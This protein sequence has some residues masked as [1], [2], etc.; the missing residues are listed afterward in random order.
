MKRTHHLLLLLVFLSTWG[1]L[2][3][4]VGR[5]V[6]VVTDEVG[7]LEGVTVQYRGYNRGAVTDS[8]G[9]YSLP[10]SQTGKFDLEF[11]FLGYRAQ[12]IPLEIE[13][14][15]LTYTVDVVLQE[16]TRLL[17]TVEVEGAQEN[18]R[19]QV[20]LYRLDPATAQALPTP[21]QEFTRILATLPG[22]SATN[23][24]SSAYSVRGGNF[25]EN[26]VYVNDIPVYRPFLVR[27]GQQEGLSFIHTDLVGEV[28]FSA[29]GWEPKYGDK[30]SSVLNIS[31]RRPD[32]FRATAAAGL[33][34]ARVH[35]EGKIGQRVSYLAGVRHKRAA[36]LLNT[37]PTQGEY[38]PRFT[39][40]Q[41]LLRWDLSAN[42]GQE[43]PKTELEW[44]FSYAQNQYLV[45]PSSRETTFGTFSESFRLFVGFVGQES[46]TYNT[47]QNGLKLTHR[48]NDRVTS[49]LIFSGLQTSEREFF[50]VEGGF[51]LCD[52]DN[53]PGSSTFNECLVTVGV[54]SIYRYGRNVLQ[55]QLYHAESR[56]ELQLG[57]NSKLEVGFSYGWQSIDDAL[58]EYTFRD[59]LDYATQLEVLDSDANLDV[60]RIE[61]YVQHRYSPSE[62]VQLI[63]GL[64][65]NRFSLN[66]QILVSPRAQVS[67]RIPGPRNVIVR[68]AAG[69]YN[70]PPFD[71]EMRA[72]DGSLN[73]DLRA[74]RSFHLI[75]G[76]DYKFIMWDRPF[77]LVS[78]AYYKG[79][80][81]LVPYDVDNVR[82]RYYAENAAVG[83]ATGLDFRLNGEFI[84]GSESWFSLGI[85]KTEE[86]LDFDDRDY[87]RRPT[88]QRVISSIFFQDHVPWDESFRVNL[89]AQFATGFP[90]GPPQDLRNRTTFVSR[91]YR[92]VDVGFS[93]I[94]DFEEMGKRPFGLVRSVWL[95]ADVL[96]MLGVAND[97]SFLWVGDYQG[98]QYAVPNSL[99]QRFFNFQVI[100]RM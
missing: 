58:D 32:E 45:Y 1:T 18:A 26:L 14:A 36:Y 30:L 17:Q 65:V 76:M 48:W 41:N 15:D 69:A 74:Q 53:D 64:R 68:A 39:D 27:A 61:G 46:L 7:P 20:S 87:I 96:N 16:D 29:G 99:S 8:T 31:Y 33:L 40:V 13:D 55:A 38:R 72:F 12:V 85:L 2:Q 37:L 97:I 60:N 100:V 86:D 73:T 92:R 91:W 51:R 56:N 62:Y 82:L 89:N 75:A 94:F 44:L 3:A 70:Q 95:G 54:G 21:F 77:K 66:Q 49:K 67:Y 28:E 43:T 5:I 10:I 24:F 52:V 79:L 59:S 93:K 34:G 22:V 4:Q 9:S 71:R 50:D 63:Y 47:L 57:E 81:D 90:F 25:D 80:R 23:E 83:Y 88:D 84:P 19:E 78:E 98:R 35:A 42:P 11:R 6:G